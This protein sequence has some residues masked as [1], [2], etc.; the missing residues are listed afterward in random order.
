MNQ[1]NSIEPDLVLDRAPIRDGEVGIFWLDGADIGH[2]PSA[3][4]EQLG[5]LLDKIEDDGRIALLVLRYPSVTTD[6]QAH[7]HLRISEHRRLEQQIQRMESLPV[8]SVAWVDGLC[9]GAPFELAVAADLC[10]ATANAR[11]GCP[12]VRDGHLPGLSVNRL[13]RL[14]GARAARRL[15]LLGETW[16]ASRAREA[17]LIDGVLGADQLDQYVY[18]LAAR[19]PQGDGVAL[20]MCRRLIGE[21][22]SSGYETGLGHFMAAQMRCD[23]VRARAILTT[24][25]SCRSL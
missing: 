12:Q 9:V 23:D 3:L 14:I 20:Q 24:V 7:T 13:P 22:H 2:E 5:A 21:A 10:F 6:A 4:I 11:F 8:V 18:E 17:G 16:D 25:P 1:L 19:L 15:L